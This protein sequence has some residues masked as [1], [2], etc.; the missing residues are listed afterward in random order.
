VKVN[1]LSLLFF[2]PF[3][4][5]CFFLFFLSKHPETVFS[6]FLLEIGVFFKVVVRFR[7]AKL[8]M[9]MMMMIQMI[10]MMIQMIE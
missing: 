5:F 1:L 4:F 6:V 10:Q 8:L 9:M 7:S 3:C 2:P